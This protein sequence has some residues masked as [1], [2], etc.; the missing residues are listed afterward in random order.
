[1]VCWACLQPTTR[2]ASATTQHTSKHTHAPALTWQAPW[3]LQPDGHST[4]GRW[5]GVAGQDA[6]PGR[7]S[8]LSPEGGS[9]RQARAWQMALVV[10][11]GSKLGGAGDGEAEGALGLGLVP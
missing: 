6:M 1:M 5:Q 8:S 4:A 3:A 9:V 2:Q 11:R 10:R 7:V